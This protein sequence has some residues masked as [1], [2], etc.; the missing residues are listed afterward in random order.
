M[1]PVSISIVPIS[2]DHAR[3]YWSGQVDA[4]GQIPEGHVSDGSGV[5]CRHCLSNVK[6][7][8]SYLI[9]SYCPF[10]ELQPYAERGP[11]FLHAQP[12]SAYQNRANVPPIYIGGEP[13]IV[14]GYDST[15][16]IIY[17]TGKIVQSNEI[18]A[19][20]EELFCNQNVAYVHVRSSE[21]NCF[22]FRMERSNS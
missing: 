13:R 2:T 1:K 4:N 8:E 10:P 15:N 14:R 20:A 7:G 21:N 3:N 5:P 17:G 19:Y 11:V 16:R 6:A 22:A 12:C 18:K 9:L